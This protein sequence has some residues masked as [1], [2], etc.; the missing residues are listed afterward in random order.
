MFKRLELHNHTRESD[1]SLTVKELI[2]HMIDN[3]VNAVAITDHNTISGHKK[4][5]KILSDN[6]LEI[7]II[8][9][10]ELTTY[11]GHILCLNLK[12][13]INWENINYNKPELLFNKIREMGGLVGIAHPFSK[14]HPYS[15]GCKWEMKINDYTSFDFIEI[16]NNPE[17]LKEVNEKAL[18]WWE[19][20]ILEGY[21][22]AMTT[23][24]DLHGKWDMNDSFHTYIETYEGE[25]I[26]K[27]LERAV[28]TRRTFIT[29]KDI[30]EAYINKTENTFS[31]KCDFHIINDK[32]ENDKKQ[33]EVFITVTTKKLKVIQKYDP[34]MVISFKIE[35]IEKGDAIIVKAYYKSEI[36]D[37]LIAI[38]PVIYY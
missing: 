35:D 15:R 37:N 38:A 8:Y 11:Y 7:E 5:E 16:F 21:K 3:T 22:L 24:M 1:S 23:G 12:E 25:S 27:S 4:A 28:K 36:I 9:G 10:V 17:P 13:Y 29:K 30:L 14:G 18:I 33:E 34:D 31:I 2:D 32:D 6:K 19:S 26:E 20:L